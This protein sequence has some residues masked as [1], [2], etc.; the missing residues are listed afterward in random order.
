MTST[1]L[2]IFAFGFANL[3]MLGWLAA[4]AAPLII[5]LLNRR[6]YREMSWAAMEFL[7]AAI[8]KQS[9]RV[10][11][12]QWILLAVRTVLITCLVLAVAEPY[13]ER[14]GL[15]AVSGARTHKLLVIDGSFSMGYKPTDKTRFD[16]AKELAGQI[17]DES[18]QGDGFT[19]VLMG[20]PPR[21]VVGTPAFEAG[22][23]VEEIERLELPHG[24]GNLPVTLEEVERI[25]TAARRE[26]PK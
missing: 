9:R 13:L 16:R 8:R 26:Q 7:L 25:L 1:P 19:L 24:G 2:A 3:A 6:K 15:T 17:V 14:A 21:T 11:I 23:F 18:S 22:R 10:R 20:D 4:A 12:E 5:H